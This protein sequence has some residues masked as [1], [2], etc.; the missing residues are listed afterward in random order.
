MDFKGRV[1]KI[2]F[3]SFVFIL[4]CLVIC[5][6][7]IKSCYTEKR[8]QD[9][10]FF[11]CQITNTYFIGL[12]IIEGEIQL[13]TFLLVFSEV[14]FTES[15]FNSH[16]ILLNFKKIKLLNLVVKQNGQNKYSIKN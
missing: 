11:F 10:S 15:S 5:L 1:K 12:K 6:F 3:I 16:Y 14:G 13:K 7:L 2:V 8:W 4:V 9:L